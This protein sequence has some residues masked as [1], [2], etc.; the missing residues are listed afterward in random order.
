MSEDL[1]AGRID[2]VETE[3]ASIRT[4][5]G[6]LKNDMVGI[7]ADVGGLSNILVRIE[8]S[9]SQAQ[10]RYDTRENAARPNM[11]AIMGVLITIISI[12]VG[13]AW[14]ISGQLATTATQL[15]EQDKAMARL[16]DVRDREVD[17]IQKRIDRIDQ[18]PGG[19]KQGG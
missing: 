6:G 18:A 4:D 5:L 3:V 11:V 15:E 10:T 19:A 8:G 17:D 9:V 2:R 12:I 14:I 7:K 13:G 16:V 1:H